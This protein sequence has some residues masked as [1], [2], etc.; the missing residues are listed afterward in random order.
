MIKTEVIERIREAADI[1]EVVSDYV[2]LKKA[3]AS[4]KGK[5]PFTDE[6]TPSFF[7]NPTKQ[8]FK[9]FSSGIGGDPIAF[10]MELKGLSFM[11]AIQQ[12]GGKYSIPMEYDSGHTVEEENESRRMDRII[13]LAR[14]IYLEH[15]ADPE[16]IQYLIGRGYSEDLIAEWNLGFAPPI[17][18][19]LS[20]KLDDPMDR[21]TALKLGLIKHHSEKNS[22]YDSYRNRITIPIH[23]AT[24]R[25]VGFGG[26]IL[27]GDPQ[28]EAPKYINPLDSKLYNKSKLLFGMDK[29]GS[30]IRK[31]DRVII[32]EGY[33][34]VISLWGAGVLNVAGACGT[35]ITESHGKI[36]KRYCSEVVLMMDE[37]PAGIRATAAG[38]RALLPHGLKVMVGSLPDGFKDVDEYITTTKV[39]PDQAID[40]LRSLEADGVMWFTDRKLEEAGGDAYKMEAA[41][42]EIS[43]LI[44][45][46]PSESI[47][48]T[49]MKQIAGKKIKVSILKKKIQAAADQMKMEAQRKIRREKKADGW[50]E[51]YTF[52]PEVLSSASWPDIKSDVENYSLFMWKAR[53]Y[54]KRGSDHFHFAEIA[55]FSIKII[56]HMEDEK[57]PMKLVQI[58]NIHGRKRTF[59]ARSKDFTS[60]S[61]F[62]EMITNFGN[63]NWQ[64]TPSDFQRLISKLYDEM[65]DGRMIHVLGWQDEGFFAFSNAVIF[66]DGRV[67][68]LDKYGCIELNGASYYIPA[69]NSIYSSNPNLF[70]AQKRVRY[71][72]S[73]VSMEEYFRQIQT[74]HR[75]HSMN[76]IL[77]TIATMFSDVIHDRISFFPILFLYGEAS[78]GKDNLIESLQAFFGK[79]QSALTITGRANTDKAKIRKFA[80]LRNMVVH[81]SEY[82][83]GNEETDLLMMGLWDRRGYE[84]ANF[85][86][87]VGTEQVPILSSVVF[88]GNDYPTYDPLITRFIAEEMMKTE[89]TDQEKKEYERL[90]EMVL[91]GVSSISADLMKLRGIFEKDFR[92]WFKEVSTQLKELLSDLNLADRMIQNSAV[93]GATLKICEGAGIPLPFTWDQWRDH[94]ITKNLPA[95]NRKRNTNSVLSQFWDCFLDAA[96]EG[97]QIFPDR[98]YK[99]DGDQLFFNFKAVYNA[100]SVNHFKLFR[101]GGVPKAVLMDKLKRPGSGFKTEHSAFRFGE[102]RT[103]AYQFDLSRNGLAEDF[104]NVIYYSGNSRNGNHHQ[105]HPDEWL[106]GKS[107]EK[108]ETESIPENSLF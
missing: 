71:L 1:V 103:S 64:G 14:K 105:P 63:F 19:S 66:P 77:F 90:K 11:E 28:K 67:E 79:T 7:V 23:T 89:F 29:S 39:K 49:Y 56:Q 35:A 99:L 2:E 95:Q 31:A 59:D 96:R 84:R 60:I 65:G 69:G 104:G 27:P 48:E 88:T 82:K 22:F 42:G 25:L 40:Q 45:L 108:T 5:S 9:C 58:E 100:Y 87:G 73:E 50:P 21:E 46:I 34:D 81:M 54:S 91:G 92:Q 32:V 20:K 106:G 13:Q 24:G 30:W 33:F 93:L 52:P 57:Q 18:D 44:A 26:R 68:Q 47:R 43:A 37:D 86:S 15:R 70:L 83:N 51:D 76:A 8:I 74:V 17:W 80:Q 41:I 4:Y 36:L 10:L 97:K 6:K 38:I 75:E 3:G 94:L 12:L 78:S 53:T 62:I 85:D 107:D 16:A 72:C 55:N 61:A 98:D 102:R 101:S